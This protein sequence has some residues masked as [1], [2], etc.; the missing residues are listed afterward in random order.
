MDFIDSV[1]LS[2]YPDFLSIADLLLS[3][4]DDPACVTD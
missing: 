1:D 2:G 4:V 3:I